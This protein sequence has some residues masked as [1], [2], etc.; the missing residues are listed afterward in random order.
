MCFY[1]GDV[2]N[3][4]A[5]AGIAA[6][7]KES[8]QAARL[9]QMEVAKE[10]EVARQLVS[11]WECGRSTPTLDQWFQLAPLY[12]VSLDYLVYGIRTVPVSRAG[13]LERVFQPLGR[14]AEEEDCSTSERLSAP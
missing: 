6:R 1:T 12:G 3:E 14:S 2:L 7:L 13:I 11:A 9:S 8:R 5:K 10:F 4:E